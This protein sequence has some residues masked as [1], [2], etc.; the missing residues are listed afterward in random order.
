MGKSTRAQF[1]T[2]VIDK[3]KGKP[4]VDVYY[5]KCGKQAYAPNYHRFLLL[6]RTVN[7]DRYDV[8]FFHYFPSYLKKRSGHG[9]SIH[10]LRVPCV[11]CVMSDSYTS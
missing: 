10:M 2:L 3:E 6:R 1:A 4:Y 9:Y 7:P 8:A 5:C 11:P